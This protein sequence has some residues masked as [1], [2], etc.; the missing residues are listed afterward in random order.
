MLFIGLHLPVLTVRKL[1]AKNTFSIISGI[2][3]LWKD[4]YY[5]LAVII[6]FF[7]VILPIVKLT[8]LF[9]IWYVRLRDNQRKWLLYGLGFLGKWSMLDVFV[10]AVIIVSVKLGALASA[11]AERG[12]YYFGVSIFLAMLVTHLQSNLVNRADKLQK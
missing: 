10:T 9:V 5:F 6:F 4:K 1:W 11:K 8:T 12:I 2:M 7:S 3:N